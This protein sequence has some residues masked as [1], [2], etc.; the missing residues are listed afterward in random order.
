MNANTLPEIAERWAAGPAIADAA[1]PAGLI[2]VV[3]FLVSTL[4]WDNVLCAAAT[5]AEF[6]GPDTLVECDA[7]PA[8]RVADELAKRLREGTA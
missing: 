7:G 4:G 1:T 2:R 5:V 6:Q 3:D 8:V